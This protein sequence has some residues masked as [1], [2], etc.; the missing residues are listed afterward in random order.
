MTTYQINNFSKTITALKTPLIFIVVLSHVNNI[1]N[2]IIF[3]REV[4]TII[5]KA[6]IPTFFIISG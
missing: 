4:I 3:F 5:T 2:D 1:Y 6:V